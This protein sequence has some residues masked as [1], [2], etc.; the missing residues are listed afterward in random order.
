MAMKVLFINATRLGDAILSLGLLEH[1]VRTMPGAE[2]TVVCGGLPAPLFENVPGVREII[3]L[4]KKPWNRHWIDLWKTLRKTRWHTVVDL[5]DSVV[6]RLIPADRRFIHSRR[7]DRSQHKVRQNAAVMKLSDDP[8]SPRIR[9]N[10]AQRENAAALIPPGGPVIGIGP[11]A[12]WSGKIWPPGCFIELAADLIDPQ[13]GLFPLARVAVF[14]APGEEYLAEEV[15]EALPPELCINLLGKTDVM[16]AAA[17]LERCAL[18]IG[19]D[20][21]LMHMAAALDVPTIG[22]FGPGWPE[23]YG[24]WGTRTALARTPQTRAELVAPLKGKLDGAPCLMTGLTVESVLKE[25]E[26]LMEPAKIRGDQYAAPAPYGSLQ[27]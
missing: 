21:G 17:C 19:N 24:P 6:S 9:L 26:A 20:S 22:L 10:A 14:A 13:T 18:Y 1:I 16:T 2:I 7:I 25:I 15:V 3:V 11:T 12:N 27:K 4:K 23:I 5:R 8:P